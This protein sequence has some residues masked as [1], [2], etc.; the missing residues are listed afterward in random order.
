MAYL[1][2]KAKSSS[3]ILTVLNDPMFNGMDYLE[4]FIGYAHVLRRVE[5]KRTYT[6]CDRNELLIT[7]L[8]SIQKNDPIP[9][10][11]RGEYTRLKKSSKKK[12]LRHAVAAFTYSYNGKEWGGYT[13]RSKDGKRC[14]PCERKKYYEKLRTNSTFM[15]T[16]LSICDYTKLKP[17]GKLIYCDPPYANS[18]E[19]GDYIFNTDVFWET[20]RQWS[21]NNIVFISEYIA[22]S[23]FECVSSSTKHMS[24]AGKGSNG[25]RLECLFMHPLCKDQ[26]P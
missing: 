23:D 16:K 10:I 25:K 8:K 26:L 14:Y 5:N 11:S 2:G 21:K 6:A 13:K 19:Y 20:M 22:P 4:P 17:K 15:N 24:I 18:T 12:S 3:H 1:G 7:L 9:N